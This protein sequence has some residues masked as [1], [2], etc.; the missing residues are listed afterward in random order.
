MRYIL[1]ILW[2]TGFNCQAQ[3]AANVFDLEFYLPS[4][5]ES[6]YNKNYDKKIKSDI[7][8]LGEIF[9]APS[10]TSKK[11]GNLITY[12]EPEVNNFILQ[13]RTIDGSVAK[14]VRSIGDW[15][16]GIHLN[17]IGSIDGFVRL[18]NAFLKSLA[19]IRVGNG[20]NSLNG[21]VSSFVEQ[22]VSLPTISVSTYPSGL[23]QILERGNYVIEKY[24]DGSFII[25][26]EIPSDMPCGDDVEQVDLNTLPRYELSIKNLIDGDGE[27]SM[28]VAYP[29]GC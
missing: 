25:R 1:I 14:E 6:W 17:V 2:V 5:V 10:N 27:I 23:Q 29:R 22:I 18:P 8:T 28:G 26:S 12:Y 4:E 7:W 13:F 3:E 19:W 11:V 15:G 9:S 16:Y 20:S 24:Q 21:R